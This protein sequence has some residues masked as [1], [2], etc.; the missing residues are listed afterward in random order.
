MNAQAAH[1]TQRTDTHRPSAIRPDEYL[2]VGAFDGSLGSADPDDLDGAAEA[3]KASV[4]SSSTSVYRDTS[5]CDHCGAHL[6]YAVVWRHEPTG[7]NICTGEI[8]AR[9]TMIVPDRMALDLKRLK[10]RAKRRREREA[11]Q[12]KAAERY[13]E[14][15]E[16]LNG[17]RGEDRFLADVARKFGRYGT[18]TRRQ[19]AAVVRAHG[20]ESGSRKQDRFRTPDEQRRE[21]GRKLFEAGGVRKIEEG[22]EASYAVTASDGGEYEVRLAAD[23]PELCCPCRDAAKG[24]RCKHFYAATFAD[25]ATQR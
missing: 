8:C 20:R 14:A 19:A 5:R 4:E 6:R 16:I 13:P 18:L 2:Y 21:R 12:M 22:V 24:N 7:Q 17:Y 11:A 1:R 25:E 3:L 23:R 10:G 15:V 9:E